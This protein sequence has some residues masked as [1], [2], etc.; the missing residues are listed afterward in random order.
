MNRCPI[1][2]AKPSVKLKETKTCGGNIELA[3][4]IYCPECK[5]GCGKPGIVKLSYD[6]ITMQPT[7]DDSDLKYIIEC[8]DYITGGAKEEKE[9]EL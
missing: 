4:K 2:H 3:Y 9:N 6:P 7:C 1:C 5:F 8:W